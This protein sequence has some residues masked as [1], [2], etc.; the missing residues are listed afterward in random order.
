MALFEIEKYLLK[1]PRGKNKKKKDK[2][3]ADNP[4]NKLRMIQ[5]RLT[6][7][8][9][10]KLFTEVESVNYK[11]LRLWYNKYGGIYEYNGIN[12]QE[13]IFMG[14]ECEI[15]GT[16]NWDISDRL[17]IHKEL[18]ELYEKSFNIDNSMMLIRKE[19]NL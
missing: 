10:E 4:Y 16:E 7:Y 11:G 3:K 18:L 15:I 5:E 6:Y 17:K 12:Y 13:S 14:Y 1:P 19:W 8:L 2:S 9:P